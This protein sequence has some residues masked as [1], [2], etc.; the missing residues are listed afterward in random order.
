MK[1]KMNFLS[2]GKAPSK[3]I[4]EARP[5]PLFKIINTS[6]YFHLSLFQKNY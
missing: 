2:L 4:V 3:I 6:L 1:L 5:S